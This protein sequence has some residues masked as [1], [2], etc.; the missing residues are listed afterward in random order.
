MNRFSIIT[1]CYNAE[2]EIRETI[3]SVLG[4]TYIDYEY[5]IIDGAS[6]D[7]TLVIAKELSKNVNVSVTIVSEPDSGIY[8]A[9][10]NAVRLAKGE[11]V[12]FLNAGDYFVNKYVLGKI[13]DALKPEDD[14]IFGDHYSIIMN[15][16]RLHP[17]IHKNEIGRTLFC[18]QASAT[19][20]SLLVERLFN[21]EFRILADCDFFDASFLAGKTFH[22][23]QVPLVYFALDGISTKKYFEKER[24]QEIILNRYGCITSKKK[25]RLM[26]YFRNRISNLLPLWIRSIRFEKYTNPWG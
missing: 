25:S 22:Y 18:H 21:T 4:Q 17:A 16:R 13:A 19:R 11:F 20:R 15:K 3:L 9:M 7:R 24:E 12:I 8:D 5:L 1:V 2:K 14:I 10:N 26:R 6:S 23:I